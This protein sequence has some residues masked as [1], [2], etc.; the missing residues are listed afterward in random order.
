MATNQIVDILEQSPIIAAI[1]HHKFEEALSSSVKVIFHLKANLLTIKEQIDKIHNA[2]KIVFI[3]LDLAEGIGKDVSGVK[4]LANCGADG[5]ISTKGQIIRAAKEMGLLTVQRFFALDSQSIGSIEDML[6]SIKP[7]LIEIMPGIAGKVI[8]RFSR[9]N[10]PVIA[11]GLIETK[12]E[13]FSA[14]SSGASAVSTGKQD[15]W[16]L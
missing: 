9:G 12:D 1:S 16:L 4:F 10:I 13:V 7:D 2:G 3:H 6:D 8:E 15:L 11:G 5:I 14:L